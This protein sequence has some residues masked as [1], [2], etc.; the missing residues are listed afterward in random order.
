M[1]SNLNLHS[2]VTAIA[3]GEF[4]SLAIQNGSVYAWGDN[5]QGELG[6][7]TATLSPNSTPGAVY[8]LSGNVTAIAA[9]DFYSMALRN[10]GVYTWGYNSYGELG[11]GLTTLG[12]TPGGVSGLSTGVTAIAAG[13]YHSL[14]V[15]NGGVYAW[16][17]N[18]DGELGDG[19]L[20]NRLTPERIDAT[21]LKNIVAIAAGYQSSYALSADGSLWVWGDNAEGELGLDTVT[22]RY[23]TPQHLLAPSGYV[24]TSIAAS[25]NGNTALATLQAV[26]QSTSFTLTASISGGG[27]SSG[28]L[29]QGASTTIA[30]H[31]TNTG[32]GSADAL[33]FTGL[34][35]S[36]SS[37]GTLPLDGGPLANNGGN[38]SGYR[39][40]TAGSTLG[41]ITFTPS[42]TSA[43][44]ATIGGNAT[45]ASTG[46][47]SVNVDA[48]AE[49]TTTFTD[50][51]LAATSSTAAYRRNY[52]AHGNLGSVTVTKGS[53]GDYVPGYAD[54]INGGNGVAAGTLTINITGGNDQ[55]A[56]D[57]SVFLLD[58]SNI[59][60]ASGSATGLAA[61]E[62]ELSSLGYTYVDRFGNTDSAGLSDATLNTY[63]TA[64]RDYDLELLFNP[65]PAG[66]PS[67]FD[68]DF[69]NPSYNPGGVN[70]IGDVLNIAVVPEPQVLGM[71]AMISFH[72]L[73]SRRRRR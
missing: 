32:T 3:A 22:G 51:G 70:S 64:S 47:T 12:L 28:R 44:N 24:F 57:A 17:Y 48:L 10:G 69:G 25:G 46:T 67:Y 55:F 49:N 66:S 37:G 18:G 54:N 23:T 52:V 41:V 72:T 73:I 65:G 11:N 7:G 68:F 4:H 59:T 15:Q 42:V 16:G 31:I 21:D 6:N 39:T 61:L 56:P 20:T 19:T 8:G 34:N 26:L 35:L 53:A 30:G 13:A 43:T 45:L 58:F 36:N 33:N 71:L 9:G 60:S 40:F 14:A 5:S 63:R 29:T 2:G 38:A 27:L 1:V 62:S 50:T